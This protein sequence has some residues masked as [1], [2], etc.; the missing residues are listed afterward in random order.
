MSPTQF[1]IITNY[2]P[3]IL[4][5]N[6]SSG[7]GK[8]YDFLKTRLPNPDELSCFLSYEHWISYYKKRIIMN[9]KFMNLLSCKPQ[10]TPIWFMRQAG[11]YHSHYQNLRK[12]YSFEDLCKTPELAAEVACGPMVDFDYDVSILFSDI[13]FPLE[14]FGLQL[15]Y[16]PGPTFQNYLT[17]SS[18]NLNINDNDIEEKLGFQTEGT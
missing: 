15:S 1:E 5:K 7:F 12:K 4:N 9:R 13:L 16:K 2:Y 3:E 8:T 6:H 14:L 18:W 11:R 10:S 17:D